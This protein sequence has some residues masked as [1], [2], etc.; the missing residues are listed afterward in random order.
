MESDGKNQ[1]VIWQGKKE[2]DITEGMSSYIY[3]SPDDRYIV[4][5]SELRKASDDP[6]ILYSI[7][8]YRIHQINL[9]DGKDKIIFSSNLDPDAFFNGLLYELCGLT[10]DGKNVIFTKRNG[11]RNI[12]FFWAPFVLIGDWR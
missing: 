8:G 11:K 10:P 2:D 12:H 1:K 9:L 3:F 7:E 5:M 6:D 4:F